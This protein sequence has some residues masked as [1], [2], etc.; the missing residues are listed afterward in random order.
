M[1]ARYNRL[2]EDCMHFLFFAKNVLE[3]LYDDDALSQAI[4]NKGDKHSMIDPL[5]KIDLRS[6]AFASGYV[7]VKNDLEKSDNLSQ[8]VPYLCLSTG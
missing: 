1:A 2:V 6:Y 3:R 4:K 8:I 5:T 7:L